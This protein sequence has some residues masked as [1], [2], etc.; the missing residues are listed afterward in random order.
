M[1]L[2][3]L[4]VAPIGILLMLFGAALWLMFWNV[5]KPERRRPRDERS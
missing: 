3:E 1:M 5:G 4:L 2:F